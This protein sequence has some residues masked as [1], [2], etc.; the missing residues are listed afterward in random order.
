ML[1]H[2]RNRCRAVTAAPSDTL[3]RIHS[4]PSHR[5][6]IR[7]ESGHFEYLENRSRGLDVNWQPVREDLTVHPIGFGGLEVAYWLLVPKFVGSTPAEAVG[8]LRVKGVL[9]DCIYSQK[10]LLRMGEFVARNM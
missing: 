8:F 7:K 3:G 1:L 4:L 2:R 9:F 10:V 6:Y 5:K